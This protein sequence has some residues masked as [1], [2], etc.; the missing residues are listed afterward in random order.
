MLARPDILYRPGS[1]VDYA[2]WAS[3]PGPKQAC[4]VP[5]SLA[6]QIVATQTSVQLNNTWVFVAANRCWN[7]RRTA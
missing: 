4:R 6:A 1:K 5:D 7:T 3:W 2:S